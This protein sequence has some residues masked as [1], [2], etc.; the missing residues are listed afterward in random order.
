M[1]SDGTVWAWGS[2]GQS[3]DGT[4]TTRYAPTQVT[5][6]SNVVAL[7]AGDKH[8]L[9]LKS[10]GTVW[11]WG[12]NSSGQLGDGTTATRYTPVLVGDGYLVPGAVGQAPPAPTLQV[13]ISGQRVTL[14]WSGSTTATEYTLYY[15]PY[16]NPTYIGN[17]AMGSNTSFP[18]DLWP[19][20]AF[21]VAVTAG[22]SNG[23]SGYS[24]IEHFTVTNATTVVSTGIE[25]VMWQGREWQK[26]GS[27]NSMLWDEANAYCAA[28]VEGGHDDW[29]LPTIEE[30][31]SLI[32]CSNGLQVTWGPG[33]S[34]WNN[35]A[36]ACSNVGGFSSSYTRP[37]ID[38]SFVLPGYFRTYW[39]STVYQNLEKS[40]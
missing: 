33:V 28:L 25:T 16:P 6:L 13:Q 29:V 30:L 38:P 19:G 4:T 3:G 10:D 21:Y 5:G 26:S 18:I 2:G 24:N 23:S 22:N 14:S 20:A 39:S 17:A 9:A 34:P 37:T 15:A 35:D 11:A 12:Y 40:A 36:R 27:E 8:S 32:V 7:S 1:K 31:R